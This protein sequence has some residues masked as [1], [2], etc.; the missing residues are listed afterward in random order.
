MASQPT[1]Q[2]RTWPP[3]A[4]LRVIVHVSAFLQ[5]K[6]G[7]K[8]DFAIGGSYP[9]ALKAYEQDHNFL[10]PYNDIDVFILSQEGRPK[11]C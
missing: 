7:K 10:L 3:L 5:S 11:P 4:L 9:T 1:A 8:I 6:Y 2:S